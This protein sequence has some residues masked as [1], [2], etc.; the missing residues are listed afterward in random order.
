M[1]QR[2]LRPWVFPGLF[3]LVFWFFGSSTWAYLSISEQLFQIRSRAFP[4]YAD[5]PIWFL[6]GGF[7]FGFAIPAYLLAEYFFPDKVR[8]VLIFCGLLCAANLTYAGYLSYRVELDLGRYGWVYCR[9]ATSFHFVR[10]ARVFAQYPEW[11]P[12]TRDKIP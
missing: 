4:V 10:T 9:E 6:V 1:A 7:G 5:T 3:V 2:N 8:I 11:C 12:R